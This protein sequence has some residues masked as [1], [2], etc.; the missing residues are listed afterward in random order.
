MD[1]SFDYRFIVPFVISIFFWQKGLL[2]Q[3]KSDIFFSI[4][5][6]LFAT[7]LYVWF[8]PFS[9]IF[10]IFGLFWIVFLIFGL[11]SLF[12][13]LIPS[14]K[15]LRKILISFAVICSVFSLPCCLIEQH[16]EYFSH[17]KYV[18]VSKDAGKTS[19]VTLVSDNLK[20]LN[21]NIMKRSNWNKRFVVLCDFVLDCDPD[22]ITLQETYISQCNDI[23]Q[24]FPGYHFIG[25]GSYGKGEGAGCYILF[26]KERFFLI[27]SGVFW[28]SDM[29]RTP[30]VTWNHMWKGLIR[31]V[32]WG[33]LKDSRNRQICVICT[34]FDGNPSVQQKSMKLILQKMVR[35]CSSSITLM[36]GDFNTGKTSKAYNIALTKFYDPWKRLK[37][38]DFNKPT[39]HAF[40][41]NVKNG[42]NI[43]WILISRYPITNPR[44]VKILRKSVAGIYPSDHFFTYANIDITKQ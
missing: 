34:H 37:S 25:S 36:A 3:I 8:Q 30:S 43:D 2:K 15:E 35:I 18:I 5:I 4:G 9:Y 33:M 38:P 10:G 19:T 31:I 21:A 27:D 7:T 41:E 39:Y 26:K 29:P 13:C 20:I 40:R 42:E 16:W 14:K 44:E 22:I 28:L 1:I 6:F 12:L 32:S 24:K 23:I 17:S 11:S